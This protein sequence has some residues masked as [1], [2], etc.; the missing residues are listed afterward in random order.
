MKTMSVLR[1]FRLRD[2]LRQGFR[3]GPHMSGVSQ[4]K[5]R[6]YQEDFT[7][8]CDSAYTAWATLRG[9]ERAIQIGD[10]IEI[11]GSDLKIAKFV[12]FD[13]ARWVLPEAAESSA[14]N[15][16]SLESVKEGGSIF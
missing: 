12:G 9:T 16:A 2:H 8:E 3:N 5:P 11:N 13:E 7:M 6:D 15:A 1:V 4:V 14:P 10:L